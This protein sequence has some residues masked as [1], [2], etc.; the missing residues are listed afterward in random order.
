MELLTPCVD[1]RADQHIE[2]RTCLR[3]RRELDFGL[4]HAGE[5]RPV[6]RPK[7]K[8]YFCI[9]RLFVSRPSRN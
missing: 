8:K 1:F 5:F 4:S 6:I 2:S 9:A 3:F 7:P